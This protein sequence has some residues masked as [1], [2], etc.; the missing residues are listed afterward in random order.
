MTFLDISTDG[1]LLAP[2]GFDNMAKIWEMVAT[3]GHEGTVKI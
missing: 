3:G 1:K 2:A